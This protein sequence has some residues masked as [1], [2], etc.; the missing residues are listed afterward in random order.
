MLTL[1]EHLVLYGIAWP[2]AIIL[3]R[4]R[5]RKEQKESGSHPPASLVASPSFSCPTTR[6]HQKGKKKN[7]QETAVVFIFPLLLVR[8]SCQP[9]EKL[10]YGYETD[11]VYL[12]YY[13]G[14]I[15]SYKLPC[16]HVLRKTHKHSRYGISN[17]HKK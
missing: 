6:P 4:C 11:D 16:L 8:F 12:G 15:V 9:Q 14:K 3:Q 13:S 2:L 7:R 17:E 5:P 1:R 10:E